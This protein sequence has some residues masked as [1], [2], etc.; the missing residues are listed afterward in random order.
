MNTPTRHTTTAYTR[1][2]A[3]DV[4]GMFAG[5]GASWC[6]L[7]P[8]DDGSSAIVEAGYGDGGVCLS[9]ERWRRVP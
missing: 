9:H 4:T 5:F 3:L 6:R 2:M 8:S 7:L 1:D